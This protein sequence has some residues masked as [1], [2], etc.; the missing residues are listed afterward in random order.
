MKHLIT[1]LILFSAFHSYGQQNLLDKLQIQEVDSLHL[2]PSLLF[3]LPKNEKQN[4]KIHE[5]YV[6]IPEEMKAQYGLDTIFFTGQNSYLV[7][8]FY[9]DKKKNSI[10]LVIANEDHE[11]KGYTAYTVNVL[12]STGKIEGIYAGAV[13][14]DMFGTMQ[15]TLNSLIMDID[16]DGDLDI[17]VLNHITDYEL[18]DE[19]SSNITGTNGYTMVFEGDSLTYDYITQNVWD[20]LRLRE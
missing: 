14:W 13:Y 8:A 17:S 11:I 9:F 19:F 3:D 4:G 18:P 5:G 12:R 1:Y 2:Y 20:N 16:G 6:F 10:G 15:Q 7:S